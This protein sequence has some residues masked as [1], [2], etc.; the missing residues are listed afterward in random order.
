M[1]TGYCNL[2]LEMESGKR[3]ERTSVVERQLA[4]LT[5]CESALI[6]NNNAAAVMLTVICPG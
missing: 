3:G 2:E 6:V 1:L 4:I 5:G